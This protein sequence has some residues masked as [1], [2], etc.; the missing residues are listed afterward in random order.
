MVCACGFNWDVLDL[1][2]LMQIHVLVNGLNKEELF[3]TTKLF[4]ETP[5][6]AS[7]TIAS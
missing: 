7:L 4:I 3:G 1:S 6:V 5:L 2:L